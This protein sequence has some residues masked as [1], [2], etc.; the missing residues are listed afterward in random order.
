MALTATIP[1]IHLKH[2][3]PFSQLEPNFTALSNAADFEDKTEVK[4]GPI[5]Q[6]LNATVLLNNYMYLI[7]SFLEA[8][9]ITLCFE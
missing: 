4:V 1:E 5:W 7:L 6:R 2:V 8:V 9:T 3:M